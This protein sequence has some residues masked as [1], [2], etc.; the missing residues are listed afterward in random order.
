MDV[1]PPSSNTTLELDRI[2][3]WNVFN[4][5]KALSIQCQCACGQPLKVNVETVTD[6]IQVWSV[7]QQFT[8]PPLTLINY[9][10]R[11][12]KQKVKR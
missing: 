7:V 2:E 12:W 3:R 1:I 5:L 8:S 9:L 11:C 4:R 6:A 10:E